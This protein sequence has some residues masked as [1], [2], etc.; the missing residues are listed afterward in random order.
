MVIFGDSG[1]NEI[2]AATC[3]LLILCMTTLPYG[4]VAFRV[5]EGHWETVKIN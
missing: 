4:G 5:R 2:L 3:F 1:I